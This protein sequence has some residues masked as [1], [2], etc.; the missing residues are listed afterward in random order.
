M[1]YPF[2]SDASTTTVVPD[3]WIKA[4]ESDS[5]SNCVEVFF[6]GD[7]IRIRDSKDR[8]G[9]QLVFTIPEFEAFKHGVRHGEF[10]R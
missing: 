9:P 8:E 6:D 7:M 3:G 10:D 1:K 5:A 4:S 2:G